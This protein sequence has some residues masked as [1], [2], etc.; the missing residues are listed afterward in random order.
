M[1]SGPHFVRQAVERT[2]D[3][4]AQ[5]QSV[6]DVEV[7]DEL[8]FICPFCLVVAPGEALQVGAQPERLT[9]VRCKVGAMISDRTCKAYSS[10]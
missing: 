2:D 3:Q 8:A 7:L 4:F 6:E 5:G 9:A 10:E 1:Q